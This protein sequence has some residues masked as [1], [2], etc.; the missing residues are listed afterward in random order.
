MASHKCI[1]H[2]LSDFWFAQNTRFKPVKMI[3]NLNGGWNANCGSQR[4]WDG[5]PDQILMALCENVTLS[6]LMQCQ[7]FRRNSAF[8][9]EIE[10]KLDNLSRN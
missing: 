7:K 3:E 8:Q 5:T 10:R 4:T 2:G 1:Y 6:K 9:A